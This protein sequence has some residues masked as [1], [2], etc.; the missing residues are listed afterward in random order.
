MSEKVITSHEYINKYPIKLTD[1]Y[2]ILGTIHPDSSKSF[3]I[4]FFYGHKNTLW[5]II[6]DAGGIELQDLNQ[7]LSFLNQHNIAVSDMILKCGR[8]NINDTRDADIIPLQYNDGLKE[9]IL[10]SKIDTIFFTSA[11]GKNNA[12]KLFFD[13]F[14]MSIFPKPSKKLNENRE[15]KIYLD[16]KT[17]RCVVLY[18][19]SNEALIGIAKGKNF[20]RAKE[21]NSE[22]TV[23]QFRVDWYKSNFCNKLN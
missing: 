15:V 3:E 9:Q 7:I 11:F 1:K 10:K 4:D 17:I 12:A 14:G 8:N 22:L 6:G 5:S 2:L 20:K 23:K 13:R 19:P 21:I 18:S 16:N